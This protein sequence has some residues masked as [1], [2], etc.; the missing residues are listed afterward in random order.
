MRP[1]TEAM[2][3]HDP[4]CRA[5]TQITGED[6][7]RIWIEPGD[8]ADLTFNTGETIRGIWTRPRGT[9][10]GWVLTDGARIRARP[11]TLAHIAIV[12]PPEHVAE[13]TVTHEQ[14]DTTGTADAS[15]E[16]DRG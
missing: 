10:A 12:Y 11:R 3:E 14:P 6:D 13:E 9:H 16:H 7:P 1:A 15:P 8:V 4:E 2:S 5:C